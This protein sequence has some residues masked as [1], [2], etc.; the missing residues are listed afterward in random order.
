MPSRPPDDSR[1]GGSRLVARPCDHACQV[2]GKPTGSQ[3]PIFQGPFRSK[4]PY[5]VP[6]MTLFLLLLLLLD[7][8]LWIWRSLDLDHIDL[9]STILSLDLWSYL[10][11]WSYHLMMIQD[12]INFTLLLTVTTSTDS[13]FTDVIRYSQYLIMPKHL[14]KELAEPMNINW[15][16]SS[17]VSTCLR[18][19]K[20]QSSTI[21]INKLKTS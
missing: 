7:L 2:L 11:S 20:C 10:I 15:K 8:I 9:I 12:Y 18:M 1:Y 6:V 5:C 3:T 19:D 14:S 17:Q 21:V 13:V 4:N 16:M